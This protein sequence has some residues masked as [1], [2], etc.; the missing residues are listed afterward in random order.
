M[1]LLYLIAGVGVAL[2]ERHLQ[3]LRWFAC[4]AALV[5]AT[6][7]VLQISGTRQL[8]DFLYYGGIRFQGFMVDPNYWAVLTCSA[9]AFFMR[10][11]K[12][13]PA[14]RASLIAVLALAILLSGSKTGLI[15]LVIF[16]CLFLAER[17]VRLRFGLAIMLASIAAIV[18]FSWQSLTEVMSSALERNAGRA[19][20]CPAVGPR[21][22]PVAAVG[23]GGSGRYDTWE[24]GL[25]SSP[26]CHSYW[27]S[28]SVP[29]IS[30]N[31]A[32]TGQRALAHNTYLQL[33][34]EWGLPLAVVFFTWLLVVIVRATA[35]GW[36][37]GSR[38]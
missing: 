1:C 3:A 14:V 38:E 12:W 6:A 8:A 27:A 25:R 5:A 4:G 13:R 26:N 29:D 33:A 7:I 22:D 23:D 28:V 20:T 16:V 36:Q 19:A 10:D 11:T 17:L 24:A 15:T 32:L 9:I 34:S 37:N 2:M 31:E 30:V 18:A 21:T 35:V